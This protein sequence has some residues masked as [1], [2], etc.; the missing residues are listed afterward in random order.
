MSIAP[1]CR[2][3]VCILW[4]R[5]GRRLQRRMSVRLS[6]LLFA[7]PSLMFLV[8][9]WPYWIEMLTKNIDFPTTNCQEYTVC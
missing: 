8:F 9:L 5:P 3:P 2:P 1:R 4:D 6:A 7:I